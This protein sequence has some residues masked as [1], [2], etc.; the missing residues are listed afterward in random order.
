MNNKKQLII[1]E[2]TV[3]RNN[4]NSD[5][6]LFKAR[7]YSKV[8]ENLKICD[9]EINV[10]TDVNDI[11]GIG[12]SI[13]EKIEEILNTGILAIAEEIRTDPVINSKRIAM[14]QLTNVYGIGLAKAKLLISKGIDTIPKLRD[15]FTKDN[16]LLHDKQQIGL[17]YY[18]PLLE[19][20]PRKEMVEHDFQIHTFIQAVNNEYLDNKS[21]NLP[22]KATIVGSYRRKAYTSGDIDV[23]IH[24]GVKNLN[25]IIDIMTN[26][27]YLIETL[28]FG[29]KK[30]MGIC[31]LENSLPRRLDMLVTPDDEYPFSLLYFTGSDKFNIAMRQTAVDMNWTLNE[32]RITNLADETIKPNI[33]IKTEEDIFKFL[34]MDYTEPE[35]R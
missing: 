32:H 34:K 11:P 27:G 30:F 14:E 5:K 26:C 25:A 24:G 20:I 9:K 4:A 16:G 10:I 1:R 8:I 17:K 35:N 2:L 15:A 7:A 12:K 6:N 28:A 19:R 33:K 29:P 18:E 22:I 31:K 13:R 21:T 3:L 23:L